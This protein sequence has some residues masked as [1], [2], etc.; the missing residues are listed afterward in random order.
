MTA[1][2][3]ARRTLSWWTDAANAAAA[4]AR[5]NSG[6]RLRAG[7]EVQLLEP[8]AL[9]ATLER[10]PAQSSTVEPPAP[11]RAVGAPRVGEDDGGLSA[12]AA[13]ADDDGER[14]GGGAAARARS[15]SSA[16]STASAVVG[17]G[18]AS[19]AAAVASP[20]AE[21]RPSKASWVEPG[22][23]GRVPTDMT[24]Q[25]IAGG[26]AAGR[27]LGTHQTSG[28]RFLLEVDA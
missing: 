25:S 23:H 8:V 2:Q 27:P 7:S 9:D 16:S 17:G 13:A 6:L 12:A 15:I 18:G 28:E 14:D 24:Q 21:H 4:A 5:R 3:T 20:G 11:S 22:P 1:A 26:S 10:G 19:G